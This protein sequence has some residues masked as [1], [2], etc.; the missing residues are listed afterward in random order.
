MSKKV[1]K[2]TIYNKETGLIIEK[3]SYGPLLFK[4]F[5]ADL[6]KGLGKNYKEFADS[7]NNSKNNQIQSRR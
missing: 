2:R 1:I 6:T 7:R 3:S 5:D 4:N